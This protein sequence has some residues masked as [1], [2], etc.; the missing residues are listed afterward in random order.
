MSKRVAVL[1][2]KGG[3]GKTLTVLILAEA[4]A[5][6]GAKVLVVDMDPQANAT[7]RLGVRRT[8]PPRTLTHCLRLGVA[9]GSAESYITGHGWDDQPLMGIDVLPSDSNLANR[10]LE[11]GQPAADFRLRK[12]LFGVDDHYDLTIIDCQPTIKGHLTT[13]AVA[14]LNRPGDTVL[15]ALEPEYDAIDGARRAAD[16]LRLFRD[17][18]GVPSLEVTGVVVNR[19]RGIGLHDDRRAALNGSLR[20]LPVLATVPLRARIAELQDAA[21]PMGGEPGL[22]NILEEFDGLAEALL[23]KEEA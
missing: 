16:H 21:L 5:R 10:A 19:V 11:A 8:Q 13:M 12:A 15:L 4:A 7:R 1:N 17:D 18:L 2:D 3:V 9:A 6:R 20:G 23:R 22:A 14:A